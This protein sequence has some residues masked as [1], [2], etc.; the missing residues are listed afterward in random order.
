LFETVVAEAAGALDKTYDAEIVEAHHAGKR[1]APSGTA[2]SLRDVVARARGL[3]GNSYQAPTDRRGRR[4]EGAI[5]MVSLRGGGLPGEHTVRLMGRH[6][7]VVLTH[8]V[9][10]REVF[11]A[12]ALTAALWASR[13]EPGFYGMADVIGLDSKRII[14]QVRLDDR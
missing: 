14:P 1:D 3:T 12:G 10:D 7:E 6:D 2:L 5:G 13:A 8:R 9:W 4:Q 11:A